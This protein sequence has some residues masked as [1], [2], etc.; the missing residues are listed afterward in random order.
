LGGLDV[1]VVVGLIV[2]IPFL[3]FSCSFIALSRVID[4][5]SGAEFVW[6]GTDGYIFLGSGCSFY[7]S[8]CN[9]TT[10]SDSSCC[11]SLTIG[12]FFR[13]D[14]D[15]FQKSQNYKRIMALDTGS[16]TPV[17]MDSF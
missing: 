11:I 16:F 9:I 14:R 7:G 13:F 17:C 12:L 1:D 8:F 6:D 4:L 3:L 5:S 15:P 2:L 10:V